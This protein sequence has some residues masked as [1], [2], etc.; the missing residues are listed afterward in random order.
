[1][2]PR[3]PVHYNVAAS[4][5]VTTVPLTGIGFSLVGSYNDNTNQILVSF[6]GTTF[7]TL[8]SA[9]LNIIDDVSFIRF[10]VKTSAGTISASFIVK[11]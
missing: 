7:L 1:M 10:Y 8:Q 6:D 2:A 4:T 9:I 5:I 11:Q 3:K